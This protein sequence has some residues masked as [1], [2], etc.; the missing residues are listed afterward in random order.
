MCKLY[1]VCAASG[2]TEDIGQMCSLVFSFLFRFVCV[3][4]YKLYSMC[5]LS[6]ASGT[7]EDIGALSLALQIIDTSQEL[8]QAA[9]QLKK[10]MPGTT[11]APGNSTGQGKPSSWECKQDNL[12]SVTTSRACSCSALSVAVCSFAL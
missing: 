6:A 10:L 12:R 4:V 7:T 11:A 5:V 2:T 3:V 1:S 8:H 9:A